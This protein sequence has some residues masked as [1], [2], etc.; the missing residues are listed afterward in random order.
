MVLAGQIWPQWGNH[1]LQKKSSDK[2]QTGHFH[3]N[4]DK[5]SFGEETS[6][7]KKK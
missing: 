6:S 1:F 7:S 4:L 3:S 5:S 2:E